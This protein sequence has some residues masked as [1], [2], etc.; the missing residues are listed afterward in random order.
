[1]FKWLFKIF[2]KKRPLLT[3][4][5]DAIWFDASDRPTMSFHINGN[6]REWRSKNGGPPFRQW[7]VSD[8]PKLG[9]EMKE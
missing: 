2:K 6:V 5:K 4:K 8:A 9:S 1:M 7:H 3:L